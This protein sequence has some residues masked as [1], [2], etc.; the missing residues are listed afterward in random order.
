LK[1]R[2][3]LVAAGLVAATSFLLVFAACGGDD[4]STSSGG[5]SG[6]G[7]DNQYV[8]ALCKSML[9]F[10]DSL[11]SATKDPSKLTD[12]TAIAKAFTAPFEQLLKDLK[13]AKPPK[14]VKDYHDKV[15]AEFSKAT[16]A[17]KKGGDLSAL[18]NM[19]DLPNPPKEVSD[20]LQKVADKNADCKKADVNFNQ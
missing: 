11:T 15:V 12:P 8:S 4:S 19:G 17:L 7:S 13:A 2:A 18:S 10:Q 16:D 3:S 1:L 14:D 20:R 6:T 5:S 9:T